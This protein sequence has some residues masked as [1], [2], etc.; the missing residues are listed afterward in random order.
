MFMCPL[1][2]LFNCCLPQQMYASQPMGLHLISERLTYHVRNIKK[3]MLPCVD[4][5]RHTL[6]PHKKKKILA[7]IYVYKTRH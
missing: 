2:S 7:C 3:G 4:V 5:N 1:W 6:Y